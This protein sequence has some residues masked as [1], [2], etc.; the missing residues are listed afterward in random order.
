V[1]VLTGE[2]QLTPDDGSPMLTIKA[3]DF[4]V[5]HQGFACEWQIIDTMTKA[6]C[7]FDADGHE[8]MSNSIAC[9]L[10]SEDCSEVSYLMDE[11]VDLCPACFASKGCNYKSAEKCEGGKEVGKV[12]IPKKKAAKK[13]ASSANK[14]IAKKKR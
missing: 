12:P 6:Y 7:Y 14:K 9:D 8:T 4:V 13:G 11:E 10:C 1:V 3:G 5:F 2:A